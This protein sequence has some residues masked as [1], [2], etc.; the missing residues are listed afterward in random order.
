MNVT[1][2]A[3]ITIIILILSGLETTITMSMSP[4]MH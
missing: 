4:H 2:I 1:K 3:I